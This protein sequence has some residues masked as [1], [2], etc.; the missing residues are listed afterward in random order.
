MPI[1]EIKSQQSISYRILLFIMHKI[2]RWAYRSAHR[3]A[4]K[5][6]MRHPTQEVTTVHFPRLKLKYHV[7]R[8]KAIDY[9]KDAP[10]EDTRNGT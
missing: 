9:I 1:F 3:R 8:Q 5:V 7:S 6:L 10:D 2:G 4:F